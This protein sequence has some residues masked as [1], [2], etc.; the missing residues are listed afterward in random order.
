V[1]AMPAATAPTGRMTKAT[2]LAR[3]ALMGRMVDF[4]FLEGSVD[5]KNTPPA[6]KLPHLS[7]AGGREARAYAPAPSAASALNA[8]RNIAFA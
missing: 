2:T 7:P 3:N 5:S 1:E 8:A 6:Q 4:T